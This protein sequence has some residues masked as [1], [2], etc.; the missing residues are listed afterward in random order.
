MAKQY[1]PTTPAGHVI[2][3]GILFHLADDEFVFVGRAPAANWLRY[4]AETGG[5]DVEV[6][7]DDRSP[8][9]PQGKAGDA[10]ALALP[11]PGAE[12]V[13][14]ARE[15][16]RRPDRAGQVLPDGPHERR[17]PAGAHAAPRH[18]RR[19]GPRALGAVRDLRR[20]PRDD[21]R[22]R[23]RSSGSSRSARARTPRTRSSRAGSRRRCR[24]STRARSCA[25]TANGFPP[26]GY[27]AVERARRQ[28]R[29]GRH[30]GLLPEPVGARLRP[31]RQVRPRL[32][33]PRRARADRPGRAAQEGHARVVRPT[34]SRRSSP[35]LF[36]PEGEGYQF[37]DLP[38]AN[39]G[40]SNFDSVRR[41]GRQ[42]GRALD[43]HRLQREREATPSRSRRSTTRSRS[44]PSCGRLGRAG[45]RHAEGGGPAA[46]AEG[47]PRV[48]S[49]VPYAKV[50]RL[51]YASGWRT[52]GGG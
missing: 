52:S 4:H 30:R 10:Q 36:A 13:A 37:F 38:N 40:S 45:R 29:L 14:G 15:G 12:R 35:R 6:E 2:G 25:P 11:G 19:A 3:D 23:A 41:R 49:P 51:E 28:L 47:R 5:Y 46:P 42:R 43:V 9:R 39:Y 48:V 21:P 31:H 26:T 1:V 50:A 24:R 8:M 16:E 34:T 33:R 7:L 17:R 20:G 44:G 22:G 27:E 32:H 18:G